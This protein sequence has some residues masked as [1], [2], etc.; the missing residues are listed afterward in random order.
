MSPFT[1]FCFTGKLFWYKVHL[2]VHVRTHTK[3]HL[4]YCSKCSYS[5]IAKSSLKRHQIQK[6]SG[7]LLPC[8][9]PGCKYTT[10]DKYRLQA[11]M[12]MNH[13]QVT[14]LGIV[15]FHHDVVRMSNMSAQI[16]LTYLFL[17]EIW[18]F[19]QCLQERNV[20][21]PICHCSFLEHKLKH[22][23]KSSH[24]GKGHANIS[25]GKDKTH[26]AW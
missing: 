14:T 24:P 13:Q 8:V 19:C 17:Y 1:F 22:H 12:R 7:L 20:A 9:S 26:A 18:T 16:L 11:H 25:E 3:E 10:S 4:H 6:H 5:S 23:M 2:N 15:L 21:C